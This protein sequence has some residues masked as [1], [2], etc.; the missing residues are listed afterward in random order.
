MKKLS[1]IVGMITA[2]LTLCA[3]CATNADKTGND[4]YLVAAYI[5]PSCHDDS[6]AH[7]YLW[8]EGRGEW[9]V[10]SKG[11]PRFEGHYQPKRPLWGYELDDDPVVVEKWIK[12]ALEHG[13]NTFVYDWYWFMDYPYLEGALNDGFLKA[14]NCQDMNFYIMWANHDVVY[15]YWNY[16]IHGDNTDLL[17]DPDVNWDQFKVIVDR[18]ITQYF[19]QP[20]YV[21]F[22]G[23]PIMSIF[24]IDNLARGFGSLE[25]TAK[26]VAYF[27]DEAKKAGYPDIYFMETFGGGPYVSEEF[28]AKEAEKINVI[29]IDA[30]SFYN[31]GGF[32]CDY[33]VHCSNAEAIRES[34]DGTFGVPVFPCVSIGWDD[35]PRFPAKGA[36]DVTR[37]SHSPEVF[38]KYLRKAKEYA[39]A[40][41]DQPKLITIN[42]WNEWVEGSYLLPDEVTGF[43]YLE[44]VRNVMG[45]FE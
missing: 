34:W 33:E 12:T 41:P 2:V 36:E 13:I 44:A 30:V 43:G 19:C 27:R 10:I 26:A 39:D 40:H 28:K 6:L 11:N 45:S 20:N 15:N 5:W 4:E 24:S 18:I 17:F 22:D 9:E 25:E 14:P 16:H 7:K 42:A 8:P 21:K 32:D 23:R 29:G 31:M 38:E 37:F 3:S 35:T 1:I